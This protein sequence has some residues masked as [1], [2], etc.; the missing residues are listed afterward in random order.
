[1]GSAG[2][3]NPSL[4]HGRR[5]MLDL[6]N[7]LHNTGVQIDIDRPQIAVISSQSAGKSS[8][9]ESISGITLPRVAGTCT[10]CPTECRLSRSD[11]AWKCIVELRFITDKKGQS[12]GQ[13]RNEAFGDPICNKA[14][15][16]RTF[17]EEDEDDTPRSVVFHQLYI[18]A[19]QRARKSLTFHL[20]ICPVRERILMLGESR[21]IYTTGLIASVSRGGN[22]RDIAMV[23]SL[24]TSYI[25]KP[26]WLF[27]SPSPAKVKKSCRSCPAFCQWSASVADFGEPGRS[28]LTKKHDPEGKRTIG[29]SPPTSLTMN[30]I[31]FYISG[32][33]HEALIEFPA[34]MKSWPRSSA[35]SRKRSENNWYC[36]KQPSSQDL[37][38]GI[39]LGGTASSRNTTF[40]PSPRRGS[41][42][43]SMYQKYLRTSNLI[44]PP[45]LDPPRPHF[46][47]QVC[48]N[49]DR[50]G[51]HH[52]E[53]PR[54]LQPLP[55]PP[56]SD[57]VGGV[58]VPP[59]INLSGE[60]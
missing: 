40:S 37:K 54:R 34:A 24:V 11:A 19:D 32:R 47:R 36:V 17:L 27:C 29:M 56:S 13:P 48:P 12:L 53:D 44:D 1:M 52:T 50:T 45:E 21:S 28:Y 10:R 41:S 35:T 14:E 31:E 46:K 16:S 57:P 4:A 58:I 43:D 2:L 51:E 26:S 8:L 38:Q 39:T 23:E 3:S 42:W 7:H 60:L 49:P 18:A 22:E 20:W 5:R 9:I 6:V 30:R 55:K 33:A 15:P 25:S 59:S